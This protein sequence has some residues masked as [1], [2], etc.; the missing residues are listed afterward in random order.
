MSVARTTLMHPSRR[1][2]VLAVLWNGLPSRPATPTR[3]DL[4]RVVI[5]TVARTWA[6]SPAQIRPLASP[7]PRWT[8]PGRGAYPVAATHTVGGAR[9]GHEMCAA[10]D[11]AVG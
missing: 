6:G 11:G 9:R 3:V 10:T 4:P 8:A 2:G 7:D 5:M 1:D